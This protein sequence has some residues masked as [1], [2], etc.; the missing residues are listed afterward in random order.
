MAERINFSKASIKALEA[1]KTGR[2][3][4][5]D[6]EVPSL[7]ICITENGT[8]TFY[9]YG[10]VHGQPQRYKIGKV[11]DLTIR[12][13]RDECRRLNGEIAERKNPMDAR[14]KLRE[15][16]TIG[17]LFDW[18]LE[19]HSKPNKR[20]WERDQAEYD[21]KVK[22]WAGRRLSSLTTAEIRE[23]HNHL[24][25]TL[26][27]YAAN[28]MREVLRLMYSIAVDNQ[29]VD[30][31]PVSA[32]P[33]AKTEERE[34]FLSADE[35]RRWFL[36]VANLQRETTRDFLL[37]ALFTGARRSNVCSMCWDEIDFSQAV[38]TIPARKFKTGKPVGIVLVDQV[39]A[40]LNR[41]LVDSDSPWVFPGGGR[42]GHL[43][44][45]KAA[46]QKVRDEAGLIDV[47]LHDLRR[48][49]GSWQAA[50]GASMQVIGKSLGHKSQSATAIY[51]RLD[52]DPVRAAVSAAVNAIEAAA[53]K[54]S[55]NPEN[56]TGETKADSDS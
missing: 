41:R 26:G 13:A 38:W 51:A 23:H 21:Q 11:D 2:K 44:D 22:H 27:P 34:R 18:V 30:H 5:Y 56:N 3:Y 1:P 36:A 47:R 28:K 16:M 40:I 17:E 6:S 25:A 55:K 35:L 32:V 4:V 19:N 52:L 39:M 42:T 33:R 49:L 43:V 8:R 9:R 37:M 50:G 12:Q 53:K 10:R 29:W 31:N 7:C 20:T 54:S 48:T 14:R 24:K 46:W 45:P 15:E